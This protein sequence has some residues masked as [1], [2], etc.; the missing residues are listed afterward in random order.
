M[1]NMILDGKFFDIEA[2]MVQLDMQN[3]LNYVFNFD[4]FFSPIQP[5]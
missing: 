3:S 5:S 4:N 1:Y 2:L